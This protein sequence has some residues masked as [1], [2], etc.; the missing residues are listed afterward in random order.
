MEYAIVDIETTG[1]NAGS[2]SIT[3]IAIRV[4]DGNKVIES[5]ETLVK[6]AHA[7]PPYVASLTGINDAM[8]ENS[9]SF[10]D[11][12]KD[13][14]AILEGRTFV[15]HNVNFDYSFIKHQ[16]NIAGYNYASKKLC[17]IKMTRRIRPGLP[18][19]S[20]GNLCDA[21]DIRIASR[22]RAGGD[23]DATTML[24]SKLL[25]WDFDG[26]IPEMLNE[27]E[28]ERQL[29]VALRNDFDRL[30]NVPGIYYFYNDS[31]EV[32]Y[33]GKARDL[34]KRVGQHFAIHSPN[35]K[36]SKFV[37]KIARIS[38]EACGT[39][40]IALIREVL[41]IKRVYPQYNTA[42]KKYEAKA[43]LFVYEDENGY[44]RMTIARSK[45]DQTLF[46][47]LQHARVG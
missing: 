39:E 33:I 14:F 8:V 17:T 42:L 15:A 32:I 3:E 31:D 41:E 13:V 34:K 45:K 21:L 22:H 40:L 4:F 37:K 9:L 16:L 29:S 10:G 7:I 47:Y 11:I 1:G 18:S 25:A 28:E 35:R 5:Y 38:Y 6:P 46:R 19:Y 2:G 20:L 12:A 43:G 24:F 26:V 23:A 27:V 36:G 30:P 44:Q